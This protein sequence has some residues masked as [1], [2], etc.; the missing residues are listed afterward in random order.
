MYL[1]FPHLVSRRLCRISNQR[2]RSQLQSHIYLRS[3]GLFRYYSKAFNDLEDMTQEPFH[4]LKSMY[5][6]SDRGK[7]IAFPSTTDAHVVL[8]IVD[9]LQD[10]YIK[11]HSLTNTLV[12]H[13][14]GV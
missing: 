5:Q 12:P 8:I 2:L 11:K 7:A 4:L 6:I 10:N 3:H 1:P 14:R 13:S 9:R